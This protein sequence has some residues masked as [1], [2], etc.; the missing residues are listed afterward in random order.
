MEYE[1]TD[2][3]DD[4]PSRKSETNFYVSARRVKRLTRNLFWFAIYM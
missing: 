4:A 3:G 2:R 1:S